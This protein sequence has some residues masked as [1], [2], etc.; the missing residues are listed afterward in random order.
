[1][2]RHFVYDT[3][4]FIQSTNCLTTVPMSFSAWINLQSKDLATDSFVVSVVD[5][6]GHTSGDYHALL[7]D[8]NGAFQLRVYASSFQ[9][10][11]A[12]A[13]AWMTAEV[14]IGKWHHVCAVFAADNDRRVFLDGGNKG[15]NATSLTPASLSHTTVG[16]LG[17]SDDSFSSGSYICEVGIW[18]TALSDAEVLQL[19]RGYNP[20]LIQ[21]N[22]LH[23]YLPL[24]RSDADVVGNYAFFPRFFSNRA[25]PT[26]TDDYPQKIWY[27][28]NDP[29]LIS[30]NESRKGG[31]KPKKPRPPKPPPQTPTIITVILNTLTLVSSVVSLAISLVASRRKNMRTGKPFWRL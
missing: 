9:S 29:I 23:M 6:D 16:G 3:V 8:T 2:S 20:N 18:R 1:M 25:R 13:T 30:D 7:I 11:S 24:I 22:S 28:H 14:T 27:K 21:T 19:A 15:T 4:G 5:Q 10:G 12:V 26:W 31:K 17:R